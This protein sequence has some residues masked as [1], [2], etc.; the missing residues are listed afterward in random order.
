M[1]HV[2][3]NATI[4]TVI[5][6]ERFPVPGETL[7]AK[8]SHEDFGGKGANQAVAIA[9]CGTPVRLLAAIGNDEAGLRIRTHLAAEG[10]ETDGIR[11]WV[12]RTDRCIIYVDH[13]GENTIV[14][15]IDA[16][17]AFDP[18]VTTDIAHEIRT[19][20]H[21]LLQGNLR[22]DVTRRCLALAKECNATT[23]L[24]PSPTYPPEEYDWRSVDLAVVNRVEAV[25]LGGDSDPERAAAV[26]LDA[27]AN[28]VILTA[29]DAGASWIARRLR[30]HAE[31]RKVRAV[32]TVGAGDVFC[33]VLV[34]SLAGG[35]SPEAAL[36]AA[37]A[38]AAVTVTRRGVVSS[39]PSPAEMRRILRFEESV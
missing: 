9:R 15:S 27:G 33:G 20:D 37:A 14:S 31:A 35:R 4:D 6:L 21:V 5:Q 29:G 38:A 30:V 39:F 22:P 36:H 7:V 8:G 3:G 25:E 23:I 16:A 34:A 28:A 13:A 24:N 1:I 10:V 12:G 19:G 26:L 18:L 11:E 17:A 32:D 2:I